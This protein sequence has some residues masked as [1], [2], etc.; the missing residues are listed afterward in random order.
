M[1][2]LGKRFLTVISFVIVVQ[3]QLIAQAIYETN[4]IAPY[5][6]NNFCFTQNKN[7]SVNIIYLAEEGVDKIPAEITVKSINPAKGAKIKLLGSK[8][9]L[10]WKSNASGFTVIV[11]K[12]L[13]NNPPTKYAWVFKISKINK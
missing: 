3:S 12:N 1:R 9:N 10:K 13:R 5:K 8:K 6:E 7:A 4:A 2:E 11:P